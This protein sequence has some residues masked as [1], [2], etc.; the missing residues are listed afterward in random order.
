VTVLAAATFLLCTLVLGGFALRR[1]S[2]AGA[3]HPRLGAAPGSVLLPSWFVEAFYWALGF[4]GRALAATKVQPDAIT[5]ASL[6]LSIAV[7]PL[8][9][10]GMFGAAVVVLLAGAA[11]DALDGMVARTKGCASPAG[12]VLDAFVDRVADAAPFV[13]LAI[14]FREHP[15]ALTITLAAMLSSSLVSYARAKADIYGLALPNGLMRRHERIAYVAVALL[16]G[17]IAPP[18]AGVERGATVAGVALIAVVGC[19]AS[20]L[21]VAR[22]RRALG[23]NAP[24]AREPTRAPDAAQRAHVR[25]DV[26]AAIARP[27]S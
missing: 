3:V 15:I 9:A 8:A 18:I 12:A 4:A 16:A 19:V 6:V 11:L 2:V 17:P 14:Y 20:V 24:T 22:T 1:S 26:A 23:A 25:S 7:A 13:G 10:A 5:Y 21:L 27:H